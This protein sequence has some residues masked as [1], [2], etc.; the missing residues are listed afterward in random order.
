MFSKE[1]SKVS[2]GFPYVF[3]AILFLCQAK[4]LEPGESLLRVFPYEFCKNCSEQPFYE[5]L[6]RP[7]VLKQF[8]SDRNSSRLIVS[9]FK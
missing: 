4:L 3:I 9:H 5:E 7:K 8:L 6:G 2:N 1:S